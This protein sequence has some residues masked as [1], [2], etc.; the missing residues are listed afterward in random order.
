MARAIPRAT[1]GGLQLHISSESASIVDGF[2]EIEDGRPKA[3][4]C[5]YR[6]KAALRGIAQI[7]GLQFKRF[8]F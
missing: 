5:G 3:K 7:E 4:A 6:E 1:D 8:F 2:F